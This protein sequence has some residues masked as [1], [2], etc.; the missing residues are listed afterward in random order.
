MFV[1][2]SHR[3]LNLPNN[4]LLGVM[5]GRGRG[6][7]KPNAGLS[8]S[9]ESLLVKDRT[10]GPISWTIL[11]LVLITEVSL[12][13]VV[14]QVALHPLYGSTVTSK[15]FQ[16]VSLL[17]CSLSMIPKRRPTA[18]TAWAIMSVLVAASPFLLHRIGSWTASWDNPTWGPIATQLF[19]SNI[20]QYLAISIFTP[21]IVGPKLLCC[22]ILL[23]PIYLILACVITQNFRAILHPDSKRHCMLVCHSSG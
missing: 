6:R 11:A 9:R 14:S 7:R 15:H 20:M 3:L 4:V 5:A 16:T 1:D 12:T 19:V 10:L 22:R 13:D 18:R 23:H 17:V 8:Q 2:N 21:H